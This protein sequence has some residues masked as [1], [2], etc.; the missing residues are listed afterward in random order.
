MLASTFLEAMPTYWTDLLDNTSLPLQ[1]IILGTLITAIYFAYSLDTTERPLKGFPIVSLGSAPGS[2]W[3]AAGNEIVAKGLKEHIG[4]FQV[5]TGTGPKVG[6]L[7]CLPPQKQMW[8]TE[9][10]YSL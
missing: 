9:F 7:E 6:D 5:I 4:P 10:S 1:V 8:P 2:S 3:S